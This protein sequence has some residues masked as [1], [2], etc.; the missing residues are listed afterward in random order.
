MIVRRDLNRQGERVQIA[1]LELQPDLNYYNSAQRWVH[2]YWGGPKARIPLIYIECELPPNLKANKERLLFFA[3]GGKNYTSKIY[4]FEMDSR[5][6][7]IPIGIDLSQIEDVDEIL[8]V[9][10]VGKNFPLKYRVYREDQNGRSRSINQGQLELEIGPLQRFGC[11]LEETKVLAGTVEHNISKAQE[12][13]C[14]L[15]FTHPGE[16]TFAN[17]VSSKLSL[18]VEEDG[19]DVTDGFLL[20]GEFSQRGSE[21]ANEYELHKLVKGQNTSVFVTIDYKKFKNPTNK[22]QLTVLVDKEDPNPR[23]GTDKNNIFT[24][25]MTVEPDSAKTQLCME[26][27]YDDKNRIEDI[28]R[29][30]SQ[31]IKIDEPIKWAIEAENKNIDIL[32]V[33]LWNSARNQEPSGQVDIKNFRLEFL[34]KEKEGNMVRRKDWLKLYNEPSTDFNIPNGETTD[35]IGLY[36]SSSKIYKALADETP[37][38]ILIRFSY[39]EKQDAREVDSGVKDVDLKI[40]FTLK[41]YVEKWLALDFGTCAIASAIYDPNLSGEDKLELLD[42]NEI[43]KQKLIKDKKEPKFDEQETPF[44]SSL[45]YLDVEG[46][47]GK[48]QKNPLISV[49]KDIVSFSPNT[50]QRGEDDFSFKAL[51]NIKI[52]MGHDYVPLN[53]TADKRIKIK[54][55]IYKKLPVDIIVKAAYRQ[56]FQKYIIHAIRKLYL[57]QEGQ[58]L[59]LELLKTFGNIVITIPNTFNQSHLQILKELI[60]E[61]ITWDLVPEEW[62]SPKIKNRNTSLFF[63]DMIKFVSESDAVAC[64]YLKRWNIFNPGK[65][66]NPQVE[67]VLIYDIGA[68]TVDISYQKVTQQEGGKHKIEELGKIGILKAG[69]SLD[70]I[71]TRIMDIH[72]KV[73]EIKLKY[74]F[75]SGEIEQRLNLV[76]LKDFFKNEFKIKLSQLWNSPDKNHALVFEVGSLTPA[77][78]GDDQTV[79]KIQDLVRLGSFKSN[80]LL[81]EFLNSITSELLENLCDIVD[82]A[83][84][85][86]SD[87]ALKVDKVIIS[88]RTANFQPL[89]EQLRLVLL[90]RT[91]IGSDDNIVTV[92]ESDLKKA[93]VLGAINRVK[94]YEFT[95]IETRDINAYYGLLWKEKAF[96]GKDFSFK[97]LLEPGE[98]PKKNRQDPAEYDRVQKLYVLDGG[99]INMTFADKVSLVKSFTPSPEK[100]YKSARSDMTSKILEIRKDALAIKAPSKVPVKLK[101]DDKLMLRLRVKNIQTNPANINAYSLEQDLTFEENTWPFNRMKYLAREQEKILK[102]IKAGEIVWVIETGPEEDIYGSLKE[103]KSEVSTDIFEKPEKNNEEDNERLL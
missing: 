94:D 2:R 35:P 86:D 61:Q 90:Q 80:H 78:V 45:M 63:E 100:Y 37:G 23:G 75:F 24:G 82:E 11:K 97:T 19:K 43:H 74:D 52:L 33:L 26:V 22:R 59:S 85:R 70:T 54:N 103:Q 73:N 44:L 12:R 14:R 1:Q 47:N 88:G 71:L 91:T 21:K 101:Y 42:L 87:S 38:C 4:N 62:K 93:V 31:A 58:F 68:G 57:S 3:V 29:K 98:K 89:Q 27:K 102:K 84:F 36:L 56:L 49:G 15:V 40:E 48:E 76:N 55:R 66:E 25:E 13:F 50:Q 83:H 60:Q 39:R 34:L 64:Y 96:G 20:E 5:G 7:K 16:L 9:P 8:D 30:P 65:E 10:T 99:E 95:D 17:P 72:T 79:K 51:P 18:R 6:N 67:Y 92:P 77:N 53:Y 81:D 69:N 41:R 46:Q 32:S 28:H